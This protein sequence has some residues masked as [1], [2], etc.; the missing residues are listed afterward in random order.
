MCKIDILREYFTWM[1]RSVYD[2]KYNLRVSYE[3]LLTRLHG[4]E[5]IF[6]DRRD[7]NRASDGVEL[8]YRFADEKG[9]SQD[10]IAI[11][12]EFPCS[13]LEMMFALAYRCEHDIMDD[14]T[15]GDRMGQ[16]FWNMIVSLGLGGMTDSLFDYDY[17]D[18]VIFRFLNREYEPN[19]SGGLFTIDGLVNDL[20]KVEI[21]YQAMWY[22][23]DILK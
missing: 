10:N 6:V 2:K 3:K 21:W 18:E 11:I 13:V 14:S 15:V 5:F 4:I 1:C 8:R 22:L 19:G 23:T 20:R 12:C 16:W 7:R 9:Y 17:V